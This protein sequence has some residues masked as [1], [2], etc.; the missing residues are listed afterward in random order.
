[1]YCL[2][3]LANALFPVENAFAKK[4]LIPYVSAVAFHGQKKVAF[5]GERNGFSWSETHTN[6]SFKWSKAYS[7]PHSSLSRPSSLL[8]PN[9]VPKAKSLRQPFQKMSKEGIARLW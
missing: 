2:F 1:M 8:P 6:R 3:W 5:H 9:I 7:I 4:C